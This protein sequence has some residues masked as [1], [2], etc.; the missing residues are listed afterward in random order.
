MGLVL[1]AAPAVEP[2]TVDEAKAHL[3]IDHG[4]EDALLASLIATSRL[5]IEAAVGIALITQ[6]WSWRLDAWPDP[7]AV[8]LP[9][10]PVQSV[11]AVRIMAAD[12]SIEA[13]S[14]EQFLVD[15]ASLQPRLLSTSGA[16]SL[17]GA[18]ALGIEIAFTAGFGGAA[19]DV[20][21]PI[22]QA[23]LILVAH[24]YEHREAAGVGEAAARIPDPVSALLTPYRRVRL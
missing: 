1:T 12:G 8:A 11:D 21:P 6:S 7:S 22:R 24:W 2:I 5:Q 19:S 23:L 3:R 17:P 4:E 18:R 9:M 16:W 20:P 15:G 14:P 13:L 10:R